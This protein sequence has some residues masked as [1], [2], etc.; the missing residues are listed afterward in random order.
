MTLL[1]IIAKS[2]PVKHLQ[3]SGSRVI[4]LLRLMHLQPKVPTD[5][6][7]PDQQIF[8]LLNI[9]PFLLM[10]KVVFLTFVIRN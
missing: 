3:V 7:Y 5:S 10:V 9:K 1:G 6:I 2:R 8:P 4:G